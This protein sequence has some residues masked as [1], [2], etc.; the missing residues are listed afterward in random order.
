MNNSERFTEIQAAIFEVGLLFGKQQQPGEQM[1]NAYAK[2]LINYTPK[3]IT[4]AFNQVILSGSAF[5]PSLA[6]ILKHLRPVTEKKEDLAPI[7]TNEIIQ[8]VRLHHFDC[9]SK[10]FHT[11]SEY[12]QA[13]LV[14]NGGT[15]SI[16]DSDNFETMKAQLERLV[17][18]VLSSRDANRKNARLEDI[19]ISTE[20]VLSL[21]K[22][23][24]KPLNYSS[25]LEESK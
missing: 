18:G 4:F 16:R 6:E 2:A 24:M 23:E 7:I 21:K 5:F 14:A 13:S 19:G 15:K 8:F 22:P 10:Y 9:E 12:A 25:L 17:K 20:N 11:L 3:Q 1:I